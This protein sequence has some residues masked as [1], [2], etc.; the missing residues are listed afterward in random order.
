MFSLAG[1]RAWHG[2]APTSEESEFERLCETLGEIGKTRMPVE[3]HLVRGETAAPSPAAIRGPLPR[4]AQS[5]GQA[6]PTAV[7]L[8]ESRGERGRRN[9][10]L[11]R[12]TGWSAEVLMSGKRHEPSV[13]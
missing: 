6:E 11:Q 1:S 10:A 3:T 7:P 5:P 8:A 2:Y 13:G 12:T 9:C 4:G